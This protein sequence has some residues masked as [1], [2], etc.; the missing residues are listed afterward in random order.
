MKF[1]QLKVDEIIDR[2]SE[3]NVNTALLPF[4]DGSWELLRTADKNVYSVYIQY[5]KPKSVNLAIVTSPEQINS[6][7]P[8]TME[9][10]KKTEQ[11]LFLFM[12]L[13]EE[14]ENKI[15]HL[16]KREREYIAVEAHN[17]LT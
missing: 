7:L 3:V 12:A 11:F 2:Y 10:I 15:G 8:E 6:L 5:P 13:M 4:I 9:E 16:T 17:K 14:I 1:S